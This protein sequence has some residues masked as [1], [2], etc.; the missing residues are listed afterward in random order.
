M[1][2]PSLGLSSSGMLVHL[3]K[4]MQGRRRKVTSTGAIPQACTFCLQS[5][6]VPGLQL[7][8]GRVVEGVEVGSGVVD[9][10]GQMKGGGTL[11]SSLT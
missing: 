4:V 10:G 8:R 2:L 11:R 6:Q 5:R 9:G 7:G 1:S 3:K